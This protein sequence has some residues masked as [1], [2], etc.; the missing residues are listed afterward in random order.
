MSNLAREAKS[1]NHKKVFSYA[2]RP[3]S[4]Q[5]NALIK[6]SGG[7]IGL[8][9]NPSTFR[10]WVIAGPEQAQLIVEFE[11]QYLREIQETHLHHEEGPSAQKT[12]KQQ[13]LA[14]IEAVND[15]GNSFLDDSSELLAL[16][17]QNVI[18]ESVI[19]TVRTVESL[20]KEQ[21]NQYYESVIQK[22]ERSIHGTISKNNLPLFKR[23]KPKAKSKQAKAVAMLKDDVA[24]FFRLYIVAR[25]RECELH[26]F[27][28]GGRTPEVKTPPLTP[29]LN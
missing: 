29:T 6:G 9:E 24:L 15:L 18:D 28:K 20:G 12:F 23:P 22:C 7:A 8:T 17:T 10:K 14:F 3:G 27:L 5:N 11:R 26:S 2:Y 21:Y 25:N 1:S 19:E 16:D 13:V 4:R